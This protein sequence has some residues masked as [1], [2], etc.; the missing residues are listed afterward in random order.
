[1][2]LE[3]ARPEARSRVRSHP[4]RLSWGI[5]DVIL[6]LAMLPFAIWMVVIEALV[7]GATWLLDGAWSRPATT[8][9]S[10]D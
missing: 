2:V 5:V 7:N 9:P 4:N 3:A 8:K 6:A 1:M 10:A